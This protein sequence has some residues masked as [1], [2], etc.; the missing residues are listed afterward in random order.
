MAGTASWPYN[1]GR[2][3]G[4]DMTASMTSALRRHVPCSGFCGSLRMEGT[5]SRPT[6]W[7]RDMMSNRVGKTDEAGA[8]KSD[9]CPRTGDVKGGPGLHRR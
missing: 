5:L 2:Q 6:L 8:G 7:R 4:G 1:D 3:A 9:R